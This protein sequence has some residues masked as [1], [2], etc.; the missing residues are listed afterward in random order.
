VFIQHDIELVY[1]GVQ[2]DSGKPKE[3][4]AG[5]DECLVEDQLAEIAVCDN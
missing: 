4:D 1:L 2:V 5:M 3:D